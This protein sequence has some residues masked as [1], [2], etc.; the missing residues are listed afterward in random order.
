MTGYLLDTQT[1]RYWFDGDASSSVRSVA[2]QRARQHPHA[3]IYVSAITLGEIEYG[4]CNNPAGAGT[5]RDRFLQFLA[6]ELPK[7]RLEVSRSTAEPYGLFRSKL[8]EKFPPPDGWSKKK[9]AEQLYDPVASREFGFDENDIWLASQ[10]IE[11]NLVLVT[12]DKKFVRRAQ[13]VALSVAAD[14]GATAFD[15]EN[16]AV[17]QK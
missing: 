17:S 2:E 15:F 1:I 16:W 11:R 14:L 13:E 8:V 10:A 7:N 5:H 12:N 6:T 9:R 4:H 3:P